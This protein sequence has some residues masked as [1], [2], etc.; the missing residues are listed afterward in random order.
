MLTPDDIKKIM[1]TMDLPWST[2]D[3]LA[4]ESVIAVGD[5]FRKQNPDFKKNKNGRTREQLDL[6]DVLWAVTPGAGIHLRLKAIRHALGLSRAS[7]C[8]RLGTGRNINESILKS[9][10][11][12]PDFGPDFAIEIFSKI[13]SV[14][15]SW[16]INGS[17]PVPKGFERHAEVMKSLLSLLLK[18]Q[19]HYQRYAQVDEYSPT[20][21]LIPCPP[22]ETREIAPLV[23]W[24]LHFWT[25]D[26]WMKKILK[27]PMITRSDIE[28]I[29]KFEK[30]QSPSSPSSPS[31]QSESYYLPWFPSLFEYLSS[32]FYSTR[33]VPRYDI[34]KNKSFANA[35][36]N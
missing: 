36:K 28:K 18:T 25:I 22:G 29:D 2:W 15:K 7:L 6:A 3:P 13:K 27:I 31:C 4:P 10:E 12:G 24:P 11:R 32:G 33:I 9:C 1:D 35:R 34:N 8:D 30:T 16:L 17:N 5:A 21:E 19:V 14:S 26:I 20:G 23:F